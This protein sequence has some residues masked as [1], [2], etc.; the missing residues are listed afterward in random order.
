MTDE[1]DWVQSETGMDSISTSSGSVTKALDLRSSASSSP[2]VFADD[3]ISCCVTMP[4]GK[5]AAS[6]GTDDYDPDLPQV[7]Q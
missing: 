4:V 2:V 3:D 1:D 5:D 7:S 6:F